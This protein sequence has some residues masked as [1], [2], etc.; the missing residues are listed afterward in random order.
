MSQLETVGE[1]LEIVQNDGLTDVQLPL[2]NSTGA[3]L[4][5]YDNEALSSLDI[6]SLASVN[7][8]GWS[9]TCSG[10]GDNED[11]CIY[12]N[13]L[14]DSET[15]VSLAY[16]A[17]S[18]YTD[19][20]LVFTDQSYYCFAGATASDET[21]CAGDLSPYSAD[22]DTWVCDSSSLV[23]GSSI[24]VVMGDLSAS[25]SDLVRLSLPSLRNVTGGVRI[26]ENDD[27]TEVS[28]PA[29]EVIGGDLY[30]YNNNNG[31]FSTFNMSALR[32]VDGYVNIHSN[33]N[34]RWQGLP[35]LEEV[36]GDFRIDAS[37]REEM[38]MEWK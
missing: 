16:S 5:I 37:P 15:E 17:I 23:Y 13:D 24:E 28:L 21:S 25:G 38:Q 31:D 12:G 29:L 27:L 7:S 10:S 3:Y 19:S 18:V 14:G 26:Y 22:D 34:M 36:G 32:H 11:V 4:K 20:C 1:Q 2:L 30:A 8:E 9:S 6:S 33:N 35:A